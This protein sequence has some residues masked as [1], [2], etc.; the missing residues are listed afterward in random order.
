MTGVNVGDASPNKRMRTSYDGNLTQGASSKFSTSRSGGT[1]HTST[2][3][4]AQSEIVP[5]RPVSR[6]E[7]AKLDLA[8]GRLFFK[9]ISNDNTDENM[10]NLVILKNIFSKQLPKMPPQYIIRLV[11]DHRHQSIV[12]FKKYDNG[13]P[14]KVVGGICFRVYEEQ[15]FAEIAFCAITASEQV[16]GYGTLVMNQL[17]EHVKV[18]GLTNFL[19]YADNYAIGYF[20]KQGFSKKLSMEKSHYDGGTLMEC[21]IHPR[22]DYNNIAT[23]IA[24]Q[25]KF[26]CDRIREI[27]GSNVVYRG[28]GRSFYSNKNCDLCMFYFFF[29]K[30][31]EFIFQSGWSRPQVIAFR[32]KIRLA[33]SL[34]GQL[35][36]ITKDLKEQKCIWPFLE[37]VDV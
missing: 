8:S 17:K 36:S 18:R 6:S 5:K 16:Q 14:A 2:G 4:S 3:S 31:I 21:F 7:Q 22:I 20:K 15:K 37:P 23:M 19:T 30:K 9:V 35:R 29:N 11:F 27:S 1:T 32:D 26:V 10:I 33:T 12:L 34:R 28:L 13:E 24:Q 25:R